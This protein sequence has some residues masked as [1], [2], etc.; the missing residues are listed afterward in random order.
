ML[1]KEACQAWEHT[2]REFAAQGMDDSRASDYGKEFIAAA[3]AR[4]FGVSME[5][6]LRRL[7]REKLWPPAG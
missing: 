2:R 5:V 7:D 4:S 1:Q 3:V 6:I